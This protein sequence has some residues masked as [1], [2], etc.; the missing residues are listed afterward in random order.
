MN[1][2]TSG[3]ASVL[4]SIYVSYMVIVIV[5]IGVFVGLFGQVSDISGRMAA[6]S[7][8]SLEALV[9]DEAGPSLARYQGVAN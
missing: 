9:H 4:P 6:G 8:E 2:N 5:F 7:P 1:S 3:I